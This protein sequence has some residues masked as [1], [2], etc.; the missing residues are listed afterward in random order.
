[1]LQ[2]AGSAYSDACTKKAGC[3]VATSSYTQDVDKEKLRCGSKVPLGLLSHRV[4]L[5]PALAADLLPIEFG[6]VWA[7]DSALGTKSLTHDRS[8]STL[9]HAVSSSD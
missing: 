6:G 2:I 3:Y 1:V 5:S 9:Q 8:S 4:C 7:C